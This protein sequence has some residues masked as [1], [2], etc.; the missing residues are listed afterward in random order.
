MGEAS[1]QHY[2]LA[3]MNRID[4][5]CLRI[6]GSSAYSRYDNGDLYSK[7]DEVFGLAPLSEAIRQQVNIEP[8]L[9][10]CCIPCVSSG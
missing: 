6:W 3:L 2:D 1:E 8:W 5:A 4:L 10:A 9:G 7:T